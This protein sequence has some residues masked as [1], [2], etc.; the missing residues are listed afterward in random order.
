[1]KRTILVLA[2]F[3]FAFALGAFA[4]T[5]RV[6]EREKHQKERI[7]EGRKSGELTKKESAKLTAEQAKIRRDER[8]AKADGKVTVKERRKL[9]REQNKA[10]RDIAKQKHDDQK[11][12]N[13]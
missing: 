1:M 7:K 2:A 3:V 5:P 12:S 4:Q 10:S 8:K 6:D 9:T 13:P 11:K